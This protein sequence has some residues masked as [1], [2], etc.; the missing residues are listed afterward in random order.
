MLEAQAGQFLVNDT[1][2]KPLRDYNRVYDQKGLN[3]VLEVLAK[4]NS[5]GSHLLYRYTGADGFR[6]HG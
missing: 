6:L 3:S 5:V 2:P 4:E 1:L